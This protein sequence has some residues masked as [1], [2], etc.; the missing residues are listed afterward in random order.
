MNELFIR[1][2]IALSKCGFTDAEI[3]K[4]VRFSK[5]GRPKG[6]V[7]YLKQRNDGI[8]SQFRS[9]TTLEEIGCIEG[10]S[11]QR[12]DQILKKRGIDSLEGGSALN[13]L[14]HVED[15]IEARNLAQEVR[16]RRIRELHGC[17]WE[18]W[19]ELINIGKGYSSTTS[20]LGAYRAQRGN[21]RSMGR[22]WNISLWEWWTVWAESGKWGKR[23]RGK[24]KYCL[25]V[26]G[27]TGAFEVGNVH[28]TTNNENASDSFL[29]HPAKKRNASRV[30]AR[31][32]SNGRKTKHGKTTEERRSEAWQYREQGKGPKEISL[33][34]GITPG[35]VA[36]YLNAMKHKNGLL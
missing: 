12:V 25:A 34:M 15:K 2:T 4:I 6:E 30:G 20:P 32:H 28:I 27:T 19:R 16:E 21:A 24:G 7:D 31:G 8:E 18:Q 11:R 9:G 17:S 22:V 1:A 36:G 33:L 14:I 26:I 10:L 3:S 35:T 23:G 5:A 13:K 29:V